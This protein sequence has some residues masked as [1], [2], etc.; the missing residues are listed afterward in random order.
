MK[1]AMNGCLLLATLDGA[2]AEIR[3]EVMEGIRVRSC[4][5]DDDSRSGRTTSSSSEVEPKTLR[6]WD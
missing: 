5:G 1:F 4:Q 6:G 2:T 3:R